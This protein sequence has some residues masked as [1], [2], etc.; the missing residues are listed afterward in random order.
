MQVPASDPKAAHGRR[1][2]TSVEKNVAERTSD[3][4]GRMVLRHDG[5][6]R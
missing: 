3:A 2:R 6:R 4:A 1:V 5:A